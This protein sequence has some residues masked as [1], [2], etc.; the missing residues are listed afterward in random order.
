MLMAAPGTAASMTELSRATFAALLEGRSR[1]LLT[2]Q[3]LTR[4]LTKRLAISCR[5]RAKLPLE[6]S[7][8]RGFRLV[9]DSEADL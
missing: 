3:I 5:W 7:D 6:S 2:R 9:T 8:E 1:R 4:T